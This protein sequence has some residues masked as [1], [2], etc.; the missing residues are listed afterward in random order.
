MRGPQILF[1]LALVL[2]GCRPAAMPMP[3]V[4]PATVGVWHRVSVSDLAAAQ[5]PDAVPA[6]GIELIRA[7]SY[8]G[9]GKLDARVYQLT[10]TAVA[11]DVMQRWRPAGDTV[12]FNSDRFFVVVKW[13]TAER[14]ALQ[15]FVREVEKKFPKQPLGNE[16]P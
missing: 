2:G 5:A 1:A 10:N 8:E 6:A 14:K 9:P 15:E 3:D 11:L 16:K 4:F 7:A 13:S 12:V